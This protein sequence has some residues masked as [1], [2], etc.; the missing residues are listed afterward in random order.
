MSRVRAVLIGLAVAAVLLAGAVVFQPWKLVLDRTVD[1]VLP[2]PV[3]VSEPRVEIPSSAA[4]TAVD[5]GTPPAAPA[6]EASEPAASEP[7]ELAR[8]SSWAAST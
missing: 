3:A 2:A 4:V 6:T 8:G 5:P 7:V 1:E